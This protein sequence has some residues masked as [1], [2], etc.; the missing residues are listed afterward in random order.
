MPDVPLGCIVEHPQT[1]HHKPDSK[2]PEKDRMS[3]FDEKVGWFLVELTLCYIAVATLTA[4]R[5]L[6]C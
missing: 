3:A 4:V 2:K 6:V 5:L 1:F